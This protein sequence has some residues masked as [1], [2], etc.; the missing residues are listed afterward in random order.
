MEILPGD[1][2]VPIFELRLA[3]PVAPTLVPVP[4]LAMLLGAV[5][6]VLSVFAPEL[7]GLIAVWTR[8]YSVSR[9]LLLNGLL[10]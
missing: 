3:R 8:C 9:T 10:N 4:L 2:I 6:L 5:T 7:G 1:G